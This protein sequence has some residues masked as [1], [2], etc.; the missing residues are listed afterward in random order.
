MFEM[1]PDSHVEKTV[2]IEQLVLL[3]VEIVHHRAG[4]AD[5]ARPLGHTM[6]VVVN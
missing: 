5:V 4:N 6:S 2:V 3:S 1:R